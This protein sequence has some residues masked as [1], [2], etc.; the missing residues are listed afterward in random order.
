MFTQECWQILIHPPEQKHEST[1]KSLEV[2]VLIDVTL[3]IQLDV[4]KYLW[5]TKEFRNHIVSSLVKSK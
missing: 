1:E 5:E 4:P 2:I 3:V